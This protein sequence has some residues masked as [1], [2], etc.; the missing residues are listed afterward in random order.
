[1]DIEQLKE[2]LIQEIGYIQDEEVVE[3]LL[4]YLKE[5]RALSNDELPESGSN[6]IF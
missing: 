6:S 4:N 3:T 5:L 1:M 2:E